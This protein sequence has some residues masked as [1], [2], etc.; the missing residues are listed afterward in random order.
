MEFHPYN[1]L[2][3]IYTENTRVIVDER[4]NGFTAI[5]KG[6]VDAEV[7]GVILKPGTATGSGESVSFGGNFGEIFRGRIDVIFPNGAVG[8]NVCFIQK[9]YL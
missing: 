2:I 9:V 5:N 3:N 7:N 4:C 6:L 8:A 1:F